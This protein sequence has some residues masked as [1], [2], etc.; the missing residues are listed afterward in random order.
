MLS[1]FWKDAFGRL[2]DGQNIMLSVVHAHTDLSAFPNL[3]WILSHGY[4]VSGFLPVRVA[5]SVIAGILL[6]NI[7]G[8]V[9]DK[10]LIEI[11]AESVCAHDA[12]IIKADL[13][14]LETSH[15]PSQLQ[16]D[17]I[18]VLRQYGCRENHSPDNLKRLLI[19]T[20]Y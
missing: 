11:F 12:V 13:E 16:H 1:A 9:P 18:G 8:K 4:L 15:F 20:Y 10:V 3:G 7:A 2:F 6:S 19:Y 5:F 14:V 17:L